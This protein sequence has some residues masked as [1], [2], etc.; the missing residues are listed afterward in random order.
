MRTPTCQWTAAGDPRGA[1][2]CLDKQRA[3][4]HDLPVTCADCDLTEF[5]RCA[6]AR[7]ARAGI[8]PPACVASVTTQVVTPEQLRRVTNVVLTG[9]ASRGFSK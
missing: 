9:V 2:V 6:R 8:V 1:R 7:M 4:V 3:P 5:C